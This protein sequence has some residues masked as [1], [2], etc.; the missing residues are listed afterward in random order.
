[1]LKVRVISAVLSILLLILVLRIGGWFFDLFLIMVALTG[2]GE[3]YNTFDKKGIHPLK[4]AGYAAIIF[5]YVQHLT[6][7]GEHDFLCVLFVTVLILS[8]IIW[9]TPAKM[10]DIE[11]TI[12][13]ILYPGF[14]L[15]IVALIK[16]NA[17]I[18]PYYL[19]YLSLTAA[20]ATDTF[21]FF[22]GSILGKNK[23]CL[24]ISPNKTIEGSIGG[25]VGGTIM[26]IL[27]GIVLNWVYNIKVPIIHFAII[28]LLGG[29]FS[30][31]GD[32]TASSI[33]RY[34]NVKDFG[35]LIPG[36]GGIMDRI[37]SLLFVLPVIYVYAQ[38]FMI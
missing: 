21:A 7:N 29:I 28:G 38:L 22:V 37:D 13:G 31:L 34:C 32:L 6:F 23:L 1:M 30:Q 3:I 35:K 25:L 9:K 20:Y 12:F 17:F 10:V 5:F 2:T 27:L 4:P 19:L 24:N 18:H 16:E 36:H 8:M 11:V 15:S 33:K 14:L 26:V